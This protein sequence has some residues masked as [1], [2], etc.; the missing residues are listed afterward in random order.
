[1]NAEYE[2]T[3]RPDVST[4]LREYIRA[5]L[6]KRLSGHLTEED[7]IVIE[8]AVSEAA[9]NICRH[10]Y[11]GECGRPIWLALSHSGPELEIRLS[12]VGDPP[13]LE[14]VPDPIFDGTKESG[15]GIFIMRQCMDDVEYGFDCGK[16]PY[17]SLKK[18]LR[19]SG[20]ENG[21]Q[22]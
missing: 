11:K 15:F 19:G 6:L 20:T 9:S 10:A 7:L 16:R 18:R 12:H 2:L 13:D 14:R 1:M 4:N 22:D 21:T 17:V 5:Y 8:L 3:S